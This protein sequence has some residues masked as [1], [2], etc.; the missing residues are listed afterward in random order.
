MAES[1]DSIS[2]KNVLNEELK[3]LQQRRNEV[4]KMELQRAG[5]NGAVDTAR[6]I[7]ADKA[8]QTAVEM[9]LL[10][11][12][13]SG[14]GIRS[15]TFNL[16]ILQGFAHLGLLRRFDYLSTVSGGGYIGAWLVAWIKREGD[17]L[18]VEQQLK[19]NREKQAEARRLLAK[20]MVVEEEPEPIYHLRSFS[21][22]LSPRLGLFSIDT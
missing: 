2:F 15:A 5:K 10:G 11:L 20:D 22:Y 19:P 7:D 16:G 3:C 1:D 4:R 21:N 12:A 6:D 17:P 8:E 14:G 18:E 9:D 13:L